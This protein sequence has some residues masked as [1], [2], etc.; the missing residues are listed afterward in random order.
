MLSDTVIEQT[1]K[2]QD[3]EAMIEKKSRTGKRSGTTSVGVCT[4]CWTVNN[5]YERIHATIHEQVQ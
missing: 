4:T 5:R 2:I 3:L 1:K